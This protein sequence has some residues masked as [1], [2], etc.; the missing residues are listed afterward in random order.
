MPTTT[1]P[2]LL[3]GAGARGGPEDDTGSP[4]ADSRCAGTPHTVCPN[5]ASPNAASPNAGSGG[6]DTPDAG[7]PRAALPPGGSPRRPGPRPG[8]PGPRTGPR[9]GPRGRFRYRPRR[10][11][12]LL[13]AA[14]SAVLAVPLVTAARQSRDFP[15]DDRLT[16]HTTAAPGPTAQEPDLRTAGPRVEA[17]DPGSGT[18]RWVH[19]RTGSRPLALAAGP[20]HAFALWSDGL[21]TDTERVT[22]S[23]VRWHRALPGLADWLAAGP[24]R[25]AGVLQPLAPGSRMLAVVTPQRIVAFRAGDGDLRWVLPAARG[26]AFDP[27]RY[28]RTAG[29]LLVAQPCPGHTDW[30]AELMAVDDL[31]R[32]VPGRTPLRN[33][34]RDDPRHDLR[35]AP[36][37]EPP[38]GVPEEF[39]DHRPGDRPEK[40]VARPR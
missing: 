29:I 7:S 24:G 19:E 25:A 30:T 11:T 31:G 36:R 38:S 22:G 34:L 39:P 21:V 15:F 28:V 37:N 33:D 35:G 27:G 23:A 9:T 26:C 32:I 2:D 17:R 18:L 40:A 12:R 8:R 4:I 13:L 5:A 3:P 1:A 10:R 16:V 6:A 20:G 14:L